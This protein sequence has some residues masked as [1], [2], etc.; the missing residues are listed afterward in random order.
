MC[1]K[2]LAWLR[3]LARPRPTEGQRLHT[4]LTLQRREG[5]LALCNKAAEPPSV[6]CQFP[7][8][9]SLQAPSTVTPPR[10]AEASTK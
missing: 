9:D 6:R 10:S 7:M 1:C 2:L 8:S 5:G 3:S 4:A